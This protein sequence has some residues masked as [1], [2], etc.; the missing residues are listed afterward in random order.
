MTNSN[1]DSPQN[2]LFQIV[3]IV[4]SIHPKP[5]YKGAMHVEQAKKVFESSLLRW[6]KIV[7]NYI[8]SNVSCNIDMILGMAKDERSSFRLCQE[9]SK[10][11]EFEKEAQLKIFPILFS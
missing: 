7:C 1:L 6:H 5:A 10:K 3:P 4:V 11:N 8:A 9:S 2:M